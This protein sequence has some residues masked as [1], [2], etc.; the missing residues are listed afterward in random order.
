MGGGWDFLDAGRGVFAAGK[1]AANEETAHS[2]EEDGAGEVDAR[3]GNDG[4]VNLRGAEGRGIKRVVEG[5]GACAGVEGNI[6]EAVGEISGVEEINA[7][8]AG[9]VVPDFE[10][11]GI[12]EHAE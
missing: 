6:V 9:R 8:L 12:V 5:A 3:L 10:S 1:F 4:G 2:E 7:I 11:A